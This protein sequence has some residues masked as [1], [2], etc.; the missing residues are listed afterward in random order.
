MV[1]IKAC[2]QCDAGNVLNCYKLD[3]LSQING[4]HGIQR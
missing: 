1:I 3:R 2:Q 4:H